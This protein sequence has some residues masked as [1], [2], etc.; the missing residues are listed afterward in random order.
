MTQKIRFGIISSLC[1]AMGVSSAV[2]QSVENVK[3]PT[4]KTVVDRG[5]LSCPGHNGSYPGF[6]ELDDKGNWKGLDIDLCRALATAIFGTPDKLKIVPLSWVQRWPALQG[7][8]VDIIIKITAGTLSRDTE[9]GFQF[10]NPYYLGTT[11]VL[12][13][14]KLG[15][16]EMKEA[17]GGT[18]CIMAGSVQEKNIANY[19]KRLGIK[20]EPV[21][22][23][24]SEELHEAYF[25]GRCDLL[26]EFGPSLA[27][28]RLKAPSPD[29]HLVLPDILAA[30]PEVMVVRQNDD[31]WLD[32]ANWM[33]SALLFAEQEGI[34]SQNVDQMQAAPP[35]PEVA[36][37]LG[38]TPGMGKPLGLSDKWAY[39]VI[40]HVGNFEE[41]Y[42]RNIGMGS[43]YKMPREVNAL[44]NEGGALYPY[45]I[46]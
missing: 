38:V 7:G 18:V 26:V 30:S 21:V 41:I 35:T 40:K 36:K 8:D 4:L 3:S 19:V 23:E 11:K 25:S 34:T 12:A 13:H 17:D 24:K 28:A 10:S 32:V 15:I 2:A 39:N 37:L 46:D 33:L 6:A 44:W 27:I 45:V 42:E 29:D 9:L 31:A 14:K 43:P 16:S 22:L 1:L 5:S 20:L